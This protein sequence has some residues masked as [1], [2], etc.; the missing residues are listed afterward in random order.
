MKYKVGYTQGTF[1]LFHIGH[2]N[3]IN[4]AKEL[5]DYL[6]VG[7]NSDH[8]VNEYKHHYPMIC[9][10]HR[11]AIVS[12]IKSVDQCIIV[13]TLDKSKMAD[14]L[15]FDAIFIGDDWRGNPRWVQTEEE[16]G[17]KGI[18]VVFLKHTPDISSTQIRGVLNNNDNNKH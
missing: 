9:D 13:D 1:D 7:V 17:H 15:H 5:C 14:M 18:K 10:R 8:L 11:A 16:L 3:V 12:N 4:Q 6:I 2:L